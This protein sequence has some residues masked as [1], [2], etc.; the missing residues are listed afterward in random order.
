MQ[1]LVIQLAKYSGFYPITTT[2]ALKHADEVKSL[3]ATHIIDRNVSVV[4]EV[5]KLTD[6]PILIVYGAIANAD[7]QQAGIDILAAGGKFV[8]AAF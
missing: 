8:S 6:K 1:Y 5:R 7:T 4:A 3:G 2:F